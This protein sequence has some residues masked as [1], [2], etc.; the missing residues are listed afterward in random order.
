M[1]NIETQKSDIINDL[2]WRYAT[3]KFDLNR[4]ITDIDLNELFESLRLSPSSFGLQPWKFVVVNDVKLRT[5]L[6]KYAW[7]Q[8]QITDAPHLIVLCAKK[9][10]REEDIDEY[11]NEI[12]KL[13][14]ISLADLTGFKE[15]LTG[16]RKNTTKEFIA[17][18]TKR[19]V[20]I[21]L[22]FLMAN[23]AKKR[24]DSC[25]MEG[26]DNEKFDKLLGLNN[27]EYCSVVICAL[28]YRAKDDSYIN[29]KKVR[30]S[31][32]KVFDFRT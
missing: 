5:N 25:P 18:W 28:G 17:N 13:R 30:F 2:E 8:S 22:G 32:E 19:Q 4:K 7:D 20:Y 24:I 23:A 14:R 12:S 6:R 21:A 15:V 27:S 10:I 31:K 29:L 1:T 26:F 11:I 16:Y 9:D 3:K